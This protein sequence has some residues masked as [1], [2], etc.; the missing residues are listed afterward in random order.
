MVLQIGGVWKDMS[1]A[2]STNEKKFLKELGQKLKQI[3]KEK[4]WTLEETEDHGCP[5]WRHLQRVESGKNV[6]LIT[7]LRIAKMYKLKIRELFELG[8]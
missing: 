8:D 2:L 6:T 3:R 1:M 4:G 5:S 7:I